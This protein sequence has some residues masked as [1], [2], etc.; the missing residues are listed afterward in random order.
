MNLERELG[1]SDINCETNAATPDWQRTTISEFALGMSCALIEHEGPSSATVTLAGIR[2]P[3]PRS[4]TCAWGR[5]ALSAKA[6][7]RQSAD[8]VAHDRP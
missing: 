1:A 7:S 8:T 5:S 4:A 2:R 3:R 6:R